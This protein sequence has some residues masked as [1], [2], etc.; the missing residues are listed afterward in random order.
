MNVCVGVTSTNVA[1]R[2]T[3]KCLFSYNRVATAAR[4]MLFLRSILVLLLY[5]PKLVCQV[6]PKVSLS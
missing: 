4:V 1:A 2:A 6:P 3:E 5:D